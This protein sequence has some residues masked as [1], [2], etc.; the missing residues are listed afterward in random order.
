MRKV[1]WDE[2]KDA[3]LDNC[4]NEA[5]PDATSDFQCPDHNCPVWRTLTFCE[6][7]DLLDAYPMKG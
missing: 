1:E 4:C 2:V 5:C 3:L 7:Q 6:N